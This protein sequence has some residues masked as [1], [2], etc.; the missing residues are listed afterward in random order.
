MSDES[1]NEEILRRPIFTIPG[2]TKAK[3]WL[4]AGVK[5][6]LGGLLVCGILLC[7]IGNYLGT[8]ALRRQLIVARAANIPESMSLADE[9][10]EVPEEANAARYYEAAFHLLTTPDR[11]ESHAIPIA[12]TGKLP[13]LGV[14]LS[15]SSL[16]AIAGYLAA[17]ADCTTLLHKAAKFPDCR[18]RI[19]WD[20][21]RTPLDHARGIRVGARLL[22]LHSLVAASG[23]NWEE[24]V[25]R[26]REAF[27]VG[28]ALNGEPSLIAQL[29]RMA[30]GHLSLRA[31]LARV[32]ASG[33]V[34]SDLLEGL[35]DDIASEDRGFGLRPAWK[36][37]TAAY[38]E[39][40]DQTRSAGGG[41]DEFPDLH[42][43]GDGLLPWPSRPG[44]W[45]LDASGLLE[46][47]GAHGVRMMAQVVEMQQLPTHERW[48]AAKEWQRRLSGCKGPQYVLSRTF[49][50]A[51]QLAVRNELDYRALL[52]TAALALAAE[53]HRQQ[54]GS[55]P[56]KLS[57]L[58]PASSEGL[59]TDP[60][61]GDP[62]RMA[63][64]EEGVVIYSVGADEKDDGGPVVRDP[65]TSVR[66]DVG[67]RLLRPDLRGRPSTT[68]VR[69]P[70]GSR[71]TLG[72]PIG[73]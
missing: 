39:L 32:L 68:S 33:S 58:A 22:V 14:K 16:D 5:Y 3:R 30:V 63:R 47:D 38:I 34:P 62:L 7:A 4:L 60:F 46:L 41:L 23:G 48:Q 25:E 17:N 29:L 2:E 13:P 26:C 18:F 66:K 19:N 9:R 15:P 27:G 56:S 53:E 51:A 24:A 36:G 42:L 21:R 69:E 57:D 67:F 52:R 44:L 49:L 20:G 43:F 64:T 70:K 31:G 73:G 71:T 59:A 65:R 35:A 40:I 8:R 6:G 45:L 1:S 55:F 72:V 37:E 28:R 54:T 50:P 61:T 12:G 10:P 11:E